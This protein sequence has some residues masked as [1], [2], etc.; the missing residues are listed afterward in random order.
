MSFRSTNYVTFA[1]LATG[2]YGG[3]VSRNPISLKVSS[4]PKADPFIFEF[5][6][7]RKTTHVEFFFGQPCVDYTS[8]EYEH[9][10]IISVHLTPKKSH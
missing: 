9:L 6:T 1:F 2:E 8:F 5:K 7:R 3:E 4:Q 10:A